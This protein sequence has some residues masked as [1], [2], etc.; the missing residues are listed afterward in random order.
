MQRHTF[1]A[2]GLVIITLKFTGTGKD[3]G[4]TYALLNDIYQGV[5][6]RGVMVWLLANTVC[7]QTWIARKI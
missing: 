5:L 3:R 2:G 4:Q 7:E 6:D 1:E